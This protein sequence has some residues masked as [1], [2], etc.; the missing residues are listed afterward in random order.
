ME[1]RA[2][3]GNRVQEGPVKGEINLIAE[4]LGREQLEVRHVR[5][6]GI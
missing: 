3:Q 4:N 2:R 6:H 5:R 1:R